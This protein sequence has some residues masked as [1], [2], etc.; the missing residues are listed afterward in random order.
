M[1][2]KILNDI[3][4][5]ELVKVECFDSEFNIPDGETDEDS[6][7]IPVGTSSIVDTRSIDNV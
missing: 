7:H 5:R 1:A 4:I 2:N 3:E 6:D